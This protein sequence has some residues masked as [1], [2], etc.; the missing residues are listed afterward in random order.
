MPSETTYVILVLIAE[1]NTFSA[2]NRVQLVIITQGQDIYRQHYNVTWDVNATIKP[3]MCQVLST[4]L[5]VSLHLLGFAESEYFTR[6]DIST[7]VHCFQIAWFFHIKPIRCMVIAWRGFNT[8]IAL[9]SN[10][11]TV[12]YRLKLSLSSVALINHLL[13]VL[14]I[15]LLNIV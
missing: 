1:H 6:P 7:M 9:V 8:C 2:A 5:T 13:D 14:N 12:N 4:F 15:T 10:W 11:S 3:L